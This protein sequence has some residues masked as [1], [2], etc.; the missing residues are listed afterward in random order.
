[1]DLVEKYK[2][3]KKDQRKMSTEDRKQMRNDE[4]RRTEIMKENA[5]ELN[6]IMHVV[7]FNTTSRTITGEARDALVN[8]IMKNCPWDA[9]NWAE[10]MMK[11]DAYQRLMDVAR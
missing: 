11:T 1:M 3:K 2:E 6:A 7:C 9:M 10:K 8:L 5:R 4:A